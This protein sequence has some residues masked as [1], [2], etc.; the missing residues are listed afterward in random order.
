[1]PRRT[2]HGLAGFQR[3]PLVPQRRDLL[4]VVA[5]A[6]SSTVHLQRAHHRVASGT[7]AGRA[8][9]LPPERL[10]HSR[11]HPIAGA[12]HWH[13][14]DRG[15]SLLVSSSGSGGVADQKRHASLHEGY[16]L[17]ELLGVSQA[18]QLQPFRRATQK[19]Q[20]LRQSS[21]RAGS[22]G[23]VRRRQA[24]LGF[25]ERPHREVLIHETPGPLTALSLVHQ[26][27]QS[28]L[29]FRVESVIPREEVHSKISARHASLHRTLG[30]RSLKKSTPASR[31]YRGDGASKTRESQG[32]LPPHGEIELEQ[33]LALSSSA[34]QQ[35]VIERRQRF[36][37]P[38][39]L[40]AGEARVLPPRQAFLADTGRKASPALLSFEL[41]L[42]RVRL[43]AP[44]HRQ[45]AGHH[46]HQVQVAVVVTVGQR[47]RDGLQHVQDFQPHVREALARVLR[48]AVDASLRLLQAEIGGHHVGVLFHRHLTLC[49]LVQQVR[50]QVTQDLQ[51]TQDA[52][53][54]EVVVAQRGQGLQ[55]LLHVPSLPLRRLHGA[56]E[57]TP[58]A[59]VQQGVEVVAAGLF[60]QRL[61]SQSSSPSS[62]QPPHLM[63]HQSQTLPVILS[64]RSLLDDEAS[65]PAALVHLLLEATL[66][67]ETKVQALVHL[68]QRLRTEAAE[69]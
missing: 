44:V 29:S 7:N 23:L 47:Q 15:G 60:E 57:A 45:E 31:L 8:D 28:A 1:M 6:S 20:C 3:R 22:A 67:E 54:L 41:Q 55:G 13:P 51:R 32:L 40:P 63:R 49:R 5:L 10:V 64:H 34:V 25:E 9:L 26:R 30:Q 2:Q 52:A 56:H 58:V 53:V 69:L 66:L 4:L 37:G 68:R 36:P 11:P 16:A 42:H 12:E 39:H 62:A 18:V 43:Q 21:V 35:L 61:R 19:S 38:D 27:N 59:D 50:Q 14:Q 24:R 46:S 17:A 33:T 48:H 65:L